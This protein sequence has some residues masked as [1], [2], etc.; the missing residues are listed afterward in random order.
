MAKT[1]KNGENT[2]FDCLLERKK[3]SKEKK[4]RE[5]KFFFILLHSFLKLPLS[6]LSLSFLSSS[7]SSFVCLTLCVCVCQS[8][9]RNNVK[10]FSFFFSFSYQI[11]NLKKKNSHPLLF[12]P[13][14]FLS[15]YKETLKKTFRIHI[16]I[17][18]Y[19]YSLLLFFFFKNSF[20][21][22]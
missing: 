7:S 20:S 9:K 12:L 8:G 2:L 13:S 5:E 4:R 6:F 14:F 22:N 18:K 16:H 10:N 17:N 3:K 19:I 1:K 21:T 15:F 11:S